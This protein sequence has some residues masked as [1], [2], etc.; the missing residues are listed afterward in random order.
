MDARRGMAWHGERLTLQR[1][2]AC[3]VRLESASLRLTEL[4]KSLLGRRCGG[5][6]ASG[7]SMRW[8]LLARA[9]S[10]SEALLFGA[11][12]G[13]CW[14]YVPP[15]DEVAGCKLPARERLRASLRALWRGWPELSL[16][17][18]DSRA[19]GDG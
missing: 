19:H 9:D 12:F 6:V 4:E 2:H 1:S 17:S 15:D 8:I 18:S 16:C 3:P 7:C 14:R 10:S 11:M 5:L 13:G